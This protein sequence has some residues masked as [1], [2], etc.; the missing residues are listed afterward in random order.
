MLL[1]NDS[2]SKREQ[3]TLFLGH[4]RS[5][6]QK[7]YLTLMIHTPQDTGSRE[8]GKGYQKKSVLVIE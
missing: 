2:K 1:V 4:V 6:E 8:T 7:T 5:V 3:L